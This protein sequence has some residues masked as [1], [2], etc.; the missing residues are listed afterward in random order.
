[1]T[2][3]PILIAA[4]LVPSSAFAVT[5]TVGPTGSYPTINAALANAND[6]D[7]IEI[8]AGTYIEALAINNDLTIV[9]I[10]GSSAVFI[11]SGAPQVIDINNRDVILEG[12]TIQGNANHGMWVHNSASLQATDVQVVGINSNTDGAGML[13]QSSDVSLV[14]CVFDQNHSDDDGGAID[15]DSGLLIAE[16]TQFLGNS[17]N[18]DGGAIRAAFSDVLLT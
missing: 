1:M 6:G 5:L 12:L 16:D 3:R 8:E 4:L 9:G 11:Q 17:A 15:I 10:G 7:T 13:V 18:D 14:D 2:A